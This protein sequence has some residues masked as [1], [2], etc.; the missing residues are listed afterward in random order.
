MQAFEPPEKAASTKG[1]GL[2]LKSYNLQIEG[3]LFHESNMNEKRKEEHH[4]SRLHK[5]TQIVY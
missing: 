5:T 4:E 2:L 1:H 3:M